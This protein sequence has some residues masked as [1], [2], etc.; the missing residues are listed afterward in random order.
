MNHSPLIPALTAKAHALSEHLGQMVD[1]L[2]AVAQASM[3]SRQAY[4]AVQ[5]MEEQVVRAERAITNSSYHDA[6]NRAMAE[7]RATGYWLN[8]LV[9]DMPETARLC[10]NVSDETGSLVDLLVEA[11]Y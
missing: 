7:A 3:P 9:T 10:A 2:P 1:L 4:Y 11:S 6:L 8:T 5:L